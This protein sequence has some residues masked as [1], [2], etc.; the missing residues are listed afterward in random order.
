MK[1]ISSSSSSFTR[2]PKAKGYGQFPTSVYRINTVIAGTHKED[3]QSGTGD[4]NRVTFIVI[5][6][7]LHEV[8][9]SSGMFFQCDVFFLYPGKHSDQLFWGIPDDALNIDLGFVGIIDDVED[10]Q[11]GLSYSEEED[12]APNKRSHMC[13]HLSE[14]FRQRFDKYRK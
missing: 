2:L 1:R 7:L 10:S 8:D 14:V 3:E 5:A 11:I 12:I 4:V 13:V 6:A 9:S